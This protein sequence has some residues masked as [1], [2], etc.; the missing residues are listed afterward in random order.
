MT[1]RTFTTKSGN[2]FEWE[3]TEEVKKAVEQ[4]HKQNETQ[5]DTKSTTVV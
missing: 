5:N 4:L 1:T 2:V 3:E